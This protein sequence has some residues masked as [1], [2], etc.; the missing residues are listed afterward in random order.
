M[1]V[2][3]LLRHVRER[4]ELKPGYVRDRKQEVSQKSTYKSVT[5]VFPKFFTMSF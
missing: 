4:G 5:R 1:V 3:D 2:V